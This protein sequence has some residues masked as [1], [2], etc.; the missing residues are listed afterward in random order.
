MSDVLTKEQ[1]SY[2]MSRIKNK[3]TKPEILLRKTLWRKGFRYRLRSNL[4][5]TPDLVFP[6]RKTAIFVDGCFWH[7]CPEHYQAPKQNA[8]FWQEKISANVTRD[9]AVNQELA[10]VGYTVVR[11]WEHEL[12]ADVEQVALKIIT[13]LQS[14]LQQSK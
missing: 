4:P 13:V 5:G 2:C 7:R 3:G 1:R 14:T 9:Q 10:A 12:R 8:Q 6:S 11:I